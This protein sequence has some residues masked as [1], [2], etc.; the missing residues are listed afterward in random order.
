MVLSIVLLILHKAGIE[1]ERAEFSKIK[2]FISTEE[3][4]EATALLSATVECSASV[5]RFISES[6]QEIPKE[7]IR[8]NGAVTIPSSNQLMKISE[9]L[10]NNIIESIMEHLVQMFKCDTRAIDTTSYPHDYFKVA[11][12]EPKEKDEKPF[13]KRTNK[14]YPQGVEPHEDTE[15][16]DIEK[17]KHAAHALS[18]TSEEIVIIEDIVSEAKKT[19]LGVRWM[20]IRPN[21]Y[22]DYKSMVCVPIVRGRRESPNRKVLAILV[23]DTNR[24]KYFRE[25]D[26]NYLAFLGRLL[27]P[28]RTMLSISYDLELLQELLLQH[29]P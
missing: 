2:H 3:R 29:N 27:D 20:D 15:W 11:L 5:M 4:E 24:E 8:R 21:Q 28:F 16:V 7:I 13:L 26:R 12:F 22:L 6:L 17:Y 1:E 14:K 18:Y 23:I 25:D 19:G 9:N 10:K